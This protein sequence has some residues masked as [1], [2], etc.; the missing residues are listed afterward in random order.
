MQATYLIGEMKMRLLV[1]FALTILLALSISAQTK[2]VTIISEQANLRGTPSPRGEVVAQVIQNEV[3]E[4]ITSR[5]AWFLVQTDRFAGWVHG[6][7]IKLN[8]GG[9]SAEVGIAEEAPRVNA[10]IESARPIRVTTPEPPPPAIVELAQD[11][12]PSRIYTAGPQ[13]GCY[14]INSNGN[15]TY[16][17][18]GLCGASTPPTVTPASS[19]SGTVN[20]RGY[21]RKDGTYVSPHTR[22]APRRN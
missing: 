9:R 3:F 22:R 2:T 6:N 12:L 17:D 14:Y 5:G 10:A 7:T 19:G 13:G 1:T 20:V 16:V 15:K 21:F 4:L 8:D 11:P 18:R